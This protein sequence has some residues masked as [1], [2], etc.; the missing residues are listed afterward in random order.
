M[1]GNGTQSRAEK[2]EPLQ[3]TLSVGLKLHIRLHGTKCPVQV[4]FFHF[5]SFEIRKF[6]Y[7]HVYIYIFI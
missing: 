6:I 4:S 7:I 5:V 3:Q 2:Q 1:K